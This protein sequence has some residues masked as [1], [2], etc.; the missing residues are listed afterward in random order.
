[1]PYEAP[2]PWMRLAL[3][4][5]AQA[6]GLAAL[7]G[8]A[9]ALQDYSQAV[10]E[11]AARIAGEL[12]SPLNRT[13]DE[14]GAKLAADGRVQT[15]P[16]FAS[17]YQ[18]FCEDGWTALAA[19]SEF[20]GQGLP[21][22]LA[23]ATTE[24]WG[25]ANLAF[26]MCPEVAVGAIEALRLHASPALRERYLLPLVSGES[27]ASM[28]LTE[29]Q[30]G[31]DLSTVT[32]S[33]V[34]DGDAWRLTGRKI[35]ISWAEHDLTANIVHLVLARTPGA[36]AGSRGLSLFVV[37]KLLP[38]AR[39]E[40]ARNDIRVISLEHK[41]GIRASPTCALTLGEHGGARGWLVGELHAGLA[42]MF[43]MMNHM[44]LGVGLHSCG[45]AERSRQLAL[46]YARERRQGRDASGVPAT[47]IAHADVRR[48]LLTIATLTQAARTLAYTAAGLIDVAQSEQ[49]SADARTQA[50]LRLGLLT[51]IVKAW[52]SDIAVEASS[53]AVQIYGGMGYMA[54][55]EVSQLYRD[56][57][58]GPIFEGTNYIQAQDLL[59][60]KVFGDGGAAL[61]DWLEQMRQAAAVLPAD[62]PALRP[63]REQLPLECAALTTAASH[64]M[65]LRASERDLT[66]SVAYPFLQ[67]LAVTAGAWQWA[68]SAHTAVA[69][70]KDP[71]SR[72]ILA[73]A[74]FYAAHILPRARASAAIIA[75]GASPV[76]NASSE[77]F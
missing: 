13:G 65:Q 7:P 64:L 59:N 26:A 22:L 31:S 68:L 33:A 61:G 12:L 3:E 6:S 10:L 20:G 47:L 56:A 58:I 1:M 63:L 25:G 27:A 29:P 50:T 39:G 30:A 51:P 73:D 43:T 15:A 67:W 70:P 48:M 52:C 32:T 24:M 45:V 38:G 66:G 72:A 62:E 18:R 28:A 4:Q 9:E 34:P 74:A 2:L 42:C 17:A 44:R 46:S 35:F 69:R 14:F 5:A 76:A 21:L 41:L 40:S 53:L 37:P 75:A 71:L 8:P 19:P 77:L 11:G 57:R 60:R 36:P 16:G 23:A 49:A 55:C 54:E